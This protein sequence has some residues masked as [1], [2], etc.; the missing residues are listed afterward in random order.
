M[1]KNKLFIPIRLV[2][3][4]NIKKNILRTFFLFS[5]TLITICS[6]A[7]QAPLTGVVLDQERQP[8]IGATVQVKG[9][10][11][12]TLTDEN[13]RYTLPNVPANGI[14]VFS[15]IGLTTQEI[16]Y[17]GQPS[18]NVNLTVSAVDLDEIV[19]V[20]Y[21][22]QTK[23][24][25]SG[26]VSA[27]QSNE[28]TRTITPTVSGA[29]VGK[30]AG[31][32][33]RIADARPGASTS[34]QIRNYGTPIFIIDG[35]PRTADD[36][37]Q[38]EVE[39]IESISVLKD[40]SAAIYGLRAENGAIL[41]TTKLGKPSEKP[42]INISGY[43][44]L[45]GFTTYPQHS[46]SYYFILG[47]AESA[48]NRNQSTTVTQDALDKYKAG[49]FNPDT[50]EDYRSFDYYDY[51]IGQNTPAPQTYINAS[52]SGAT[53][54]ANYFFS[55]ANYSQDAVIESYFFKRTSMQANLEAK[56]AKGLKI[57]TQT[58]GR[59][60][61]RHQAGVPGVDDYPNIFSALMRNWPT[62][63]P[64]ANDNPLY[65]ANNHSPNINPA[66]YKEEI[67]GYTNDRIWN[68]R[69]NFYSEYSTNFGLKAR[70]TIAYSFNMNGLEC[71]EYNYDVYTYNYQTKEYNMV[72]GGGN[73][74]PYLN[75]NRNFN[76]DIFLQGQLSYNKTFGKHS[77]SAVTAYESTKSDDKRLSVHIVPPN[78]YIPLLNLINCD[79]VND[80]W[81]MA[82][83]VSYIGRFNYNYSEKYLLEVLGRYDGSYMYA[84][85]KRFGL[86][87][88]VSL[89]WRISNE[90]FF[91]PLKGIISELKLRASYGVTGS[92]TGV[93]AFDYQEGFN[94][95]TSTY[96]FGGVSTAGLRPRG[97]PV[98]SLTWVKNKST[99]IG[100]DISLF[101]GKINGTFDIFQRKRTGIPAAKYDVLLPSEVGYTL[102]NVNLNSSANLG[103]EGMV[104]YTTKI[105]P[106]SYT[107]GVNATLARQRSLETYKPRFG[108]SYDEYMS[109]REDRW[110][111]IN[112]GYHVIG[113]FTSMDQI[114]DYPVNIDGQG[115]RNILPGD[116]I[117]EDVNND[118]IISDLDRVPIGYATGTN[119]YMSFGLT[120]TFRWKGI[121]LLLDFAGGSMQ[122]FSPGTGAL[123]VP[124]ANNG[125]SPQYLLSDRWHRADPFD[126]TSE[127]IPGRFPAT[128]KDYTS[129]SNF[130]RTNDFYNINVSYIRLRNLELG[131]DV[132]AKWLQAIKTQ[133]MRVYMNASNLFSIDNI[134]K[135]YH[136][137][138]EVA[139]SDGRVYPPSRV[140]NFGLNISL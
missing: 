52:A 94:W 100:F 127:W 17:T 60:E 4:R 135:A 72:V 35:V 93:N 115:N 24:T 139:S 48:Q 3:S 124:Y 126:P 59:I 55:L 40:A 106:V 81:T 121:N 98:T 119:P 44:G 37:N 13:G 53:E 45:Q 74:N 23:K 56:L 19:V 7:Q 32:T 86:F 89:G 120:N 1:E 107:I 70:G 73:K 77:I 130:S 49:Y 34:V 90:G 8:I 99:D 15:F 129:H 54:R 11:I 111:D 110:T 36:F 50:G 78:N 21:S 133:R 68:F 27:I 83:R 138:P 96:L 114:A 30:M 47:Q 137:D 28:L 82:S 109:S 88:G 85:G 66:T 123:I 62:E 42:T 104:D 122:T 57:G 38:L 6:Y 58:T 131:W 29:I 128:R 65:M 92:E 112:W 87:P 18:V 69:S 61:F 97:L 67:T 71:F 25:L 63:R 101:D 105:G 125:A 84:P 2:S 43:Y 5:L 102:P 118:H 51:V 16:P 91:A 12:G 39:N 134:R 33:A 140:I 41:V 116:L 132:P 136:L 9:T 79:I 31:V 22:T 10:S 80:R 14:L 117:Y 64:Y 108:N 95:A 26:A 46:N 76:W 75:K 113:Q 20:G 103:V